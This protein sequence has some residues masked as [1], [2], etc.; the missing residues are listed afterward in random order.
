MSGFKTFGQRLRGA[1][2]RLRKLRDGF[3][4]F[5]LSL[6]LM[7][8]IPLL[9][10]VIEWIKLGHLNN[11]TC[12]ITTT[13]LSAPL[14][15]QAEHD[16][17]RA[18]YGFLFLITIVLYAMSVGAKVTPGVDRYAG[19]LLLSA[20]IVH[21]FERLSWHVVLNRPLFAQGDEN[22]DGK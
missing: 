7:I 9:P 8:L 21:L 3:S 2:S 13:V 16:F 1:I 20:V 12:L 5:L 19:V 17:P 6:V 18:V 10:V 4:T 11:L 15:I 14:Y 22:R